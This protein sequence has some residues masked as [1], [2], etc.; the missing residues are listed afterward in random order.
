[1]PFPITHIPIKLKPDTPTK[2]D[3]KEL[4]EELHSIG[5]TCSD[6]TLE[7]LARSKEDVLKQIPDGEFQGFQ[8]YRNADKQQIA[9]LLKDGGVL[10]SLD[11]VVLLDQ[12]LHAE[13][14]PMESVPMSEY[15]RTVGQPDHFDYLMEH[16]LTFPGQKSS[17]EYKDNGT[18][19]KAIKDVFVKIANNISSALVTGL[20]KPLMEASLAR[21][22]SPV[23]DKETNY[24]SGLQ[25][26]SILLVSGYDRKL[27]QADGIGVVN[28]EYRLQISDYKKKKT[29][30]NDS[31][32]TVTVRAATYTDPQ[33]L[34][35]EV[36]FLKA[37]LKSRMFVPKDI[38]MPDSHI[39]V[40]DMMP[41]ANSDTFIHSLPLEQ[42][43]SDIFPVMV[44]YSPDLQNVGFID[45]TES[46]SEVTYS[47]SV[48]CG[49]SASFGAKIATGVQ[50]T[51][52]AGIVKA[53]MSF[54]IEVSFSEQWN[55]SR[56]EQV[57]YK[58]PGGARAYLYRGYFKCAVLKYNAKAM[59]YT[60]EPP[61]DFNSNVI[62]TTE[63]PI[64]LNSAVIYDMVKAA[65]PR[66][67]WESLGSAPV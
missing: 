27:Q 18:T 63:N 51:A 29:H 49:F 50:M 20:D 66:P 17:Q 59:E 56:T 30:H 19:V 16:Y 13:W 37:H 44:M 4:R 9:E 34:E 35:D 12:S 8:F 58:V 5:L 40:Y 42:T 45:N 47:V 23:S 62:K 65:G 54:S 2:V 41:P 60:Y 7:N 10:T 48:T 57:S 67:L 1:M 55:E 32:L 26:R 3:V 43:E 6:T 22:L 36:N 28:V 39:T 11:Q 61:L 25:N 21:I 15:L 38:P 24:D 31:L 33:E 46:K 14:A 52:N 53:G 64:V